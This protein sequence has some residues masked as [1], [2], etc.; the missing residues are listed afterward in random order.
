LLGLVFLHNFTVAISYAI[1]Y[2]E[3]PECAHR[4][5]LATNRLK[6][7]KDRIM[8]NQQRLGRYIAIALVSGVICGEVG[9]LLLTNQAL[10]QQISNYLDLGANIFLRL[11]KMI[12]APLVFTTL[13]AGIASLNSAQSLGR[14]FLKAMVVFI[15]GGLSVLILGMVLA[16]VFAPGRVLHEALL[17][18]GNANLLDVKQ[19]VC[20]ECQITL[21]KFIE[22][23][24]PNSVVQGFAEN[25]MLQVIILALL[26]GV[27]GLNLG[28]R[29]RQVFAFFELLAQLL[30]KIIN[31]IM[32]LSPLAVFTSLCKIVL[33]SGIEILRVYLIYILEYYLGLALIWLIWLTVGYIISG[34]KFIP[35]I[36]ANLPL[37]ATAFAASSSESILPAMLANFPR[38]GVSEKVSSLVV[39][40]G[41]AFNLEAAMFNC[42]FATLFIIQIFGYSLS[43]SQ[44]ILMLLMLMVTTK[45]IAGVPRASLV[46]VAAT[47]AAFGFPESGILIILPID[48]I[49]DMGRSATSA[50]TQTMS[51]VVVD[52]WEK[53]KREMVY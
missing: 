9:H 26:V 5:Y 43:L 29:F 18:S 16:E 23:V 3:L 17:T 31:Y 35:L 13:L 41:Y 7:F 10:I 44:E 51:A 24:I 1:S 50:F 34:R 36:K 49:N 4:S 22:E 32:W 46:V 6:A 21:K 19:S 37:Y 25:H 39:P 28:R 38:F 40:L 33:F 30:F 47:L 2:N 12:V 48:A 11:I 15:I 27:A 14:L 8:N 20:Q 52:Q 53:P 42:T 45:G